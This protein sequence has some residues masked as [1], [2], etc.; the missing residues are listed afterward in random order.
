MHK[1]APEHIADENFKDLTFVMNLTDCLQQRY[2]DD[3]VR[4]EIGAKRSGD[5]VTVTCDN[6][7]VTQ[8]RIYSDRPVRSVAVNGEL[9]QTVDQGAW[10]DAMPAACASL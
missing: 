6:V 5:T 7:P 1:H 3:G 2:Y 4:G 9:W 8:L 10:V